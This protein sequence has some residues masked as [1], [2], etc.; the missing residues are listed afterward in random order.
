MTSISLCI[1]DVFTYHIPKITNLCTAQF[2]KT[3]HMKF[4]CFLQHIDYVRNFLINFTI[5]TIRDI[6][7]FL[8]LRKPAIHVNGLIEVVVSWKSVIRVE[9]S[10]RMSSAGHAARIKE[11]INA[12]TTSSENVRRRNHM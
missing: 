3:R 4:R 2:M 5:H 9:N 6:L 11:S 12:N 7:M 10:K 8:R 1:C